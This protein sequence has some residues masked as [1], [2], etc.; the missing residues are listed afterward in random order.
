MSDQRQ[1]LEEK[2]EARDYGTHVYHVWRFIYSGG[3]IEY[4]KRWVKK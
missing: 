1:L 4:I 2:H 3:E